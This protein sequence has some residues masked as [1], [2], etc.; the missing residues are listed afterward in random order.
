MGRNKTDITNNNHFE[1]GGHHNN[2]S[3]SQS[4]E[5]NTTIGADVVKVLQIVL[6][7][8][9]MIVLSPIWLPYLLARGVYDKLTDNGGNN[10][11]R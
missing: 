4:F 6:G 10:E 2:V 7:F 1:I 3:V 8:V 5:N 9:A 11:P